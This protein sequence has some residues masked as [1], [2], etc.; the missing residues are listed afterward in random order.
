[1]IAFFKIT[2]LLAQIS[3]TVSLAQKPIKSNLTPRVESSNIIGSFL[4]CAD[5]CSRGQKQNKERNKALQLISEIESQTI[6]NSASLEDFIGSWEL[7]FCNDDIT[8]SSPFFSA[9][10]KSLDGRKSMVPFP[11]FIKP[12]LSESIYFVT[13]SIPSP[14]KS[15]GKAIQEISYE[16][17]L[18]E[19]L[20]RAVL[21]SKVE[22]EALKTQSSIMTTRS[23]LQINTNENQNSIMDIEVLTTEVVTDNPAIDILKSTFTPF[24]R[25]TGFSQFADALEVFPSGELLEKI[26]E[27]SSKIRMEVTFLDKNLRIVRPMNGLEVEKDLV[28]VYKKTST[29]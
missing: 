8:R 26:K 1:M 19:N 28:F 17:S 24:L 4:E 20:K 23:T 3:I 7:V 22:V 16:Q 13:D 25:S 14:L 6:I 27:N 11:P 15:I 10:R 2:V 5:A 9:F 21:V 18:D 12:E 29:T